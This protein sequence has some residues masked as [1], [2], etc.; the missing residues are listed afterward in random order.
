M[1]LNATTAHSNIFSRAATALITPTAASAT[2]SLT[3]AKPNETDALKTQPTQTDAAPAN[4]FQQL[5]SDLQSVLIKM[6]G[7]STG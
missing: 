5:S 4:P 1:S 6:Q 3:P 2:P 7:G